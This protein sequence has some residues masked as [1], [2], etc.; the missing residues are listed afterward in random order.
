MSTGS[1]RY[2]TV[3]SKQ[4]YPGS[5]LS[6]T[7]KMSENNNANA[8]PIVE[9][10][11]SEIQFRSVNIN[12]TNTSYGIGKYKKS[13]ANAISTTK[14]TWYSW[15]PKSLWDQFRRVANAYF[16]AISILMVSSTTFTSLLLVNKGV[17]NS[18]LR[19]YL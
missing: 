14:Y 6:L 15:L 5:S 4:I 9:N 2:L 7:S 8:N 18:P 16:L 12:V 10:A 11:E 3:A 17:P 19:N 13:Y 1:I